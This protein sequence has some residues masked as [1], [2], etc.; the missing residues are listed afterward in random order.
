[1]VVLAVVEEDRAQERRLVR[2]VVQQCDQDLPMIPQ[3]V[4]FRRLDQQRSNVAELG[5]QVCAGGL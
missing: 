1:M 3:L 2:G 4:V 5:V